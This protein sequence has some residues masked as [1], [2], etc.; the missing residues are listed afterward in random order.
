MSIVV[1][2][3]SFCQ[4]KEML[5]YSLHQLTKE[6]LTMCYQTFMNYSRFVIPYGAT[7]G[8]GFPTDPFKKYILSDIAQR[9][10]PKAEIYILHFNFSNEFN[11]NESSMPFFFKR[12]FKLMGA[13]QQF[14]SPVKA[15]V[16]DSFAVK[17]IHYKKKSVKNLF[18]YTLIKRLFTDFFPGASMLK[19]ERFSPSRRSM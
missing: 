6:I 16:A 14:H 11:L 12:C 19:N 18:I 8:Y 1:F 9:F 3:A 10:C 7:A 4:L 17:T 15:S 13:F 2:K 5:A